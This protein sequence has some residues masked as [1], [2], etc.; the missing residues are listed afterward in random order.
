MRNVTGNVVKGEDFFN[1][2]TEIAQF[3]EALEAHNLLLL[4]PRRVGKT[5]LMY[6]MQEQAAGH[7]YRA[8]FFDTSD[9]ADEAAFV[10]RLFT[11]IQQA[12]VTEESFWRRLKDS[13]VGRCFSRIGSASGFG[14]KLELKEAS[15]DWAEVGEELAR[16]LSQEETRWLIEIDELPVFVLRLLQHGGDGAVERVRLFL[17]WLRRLRLDPACEQVRWLLAG[18]VGL[19]TVTMRH[20]MADT[21]ND[22]ASVKL[23]AFSP[24]VAGRFL[25]TLTATYPRINFPA[26]VQAYAVHKIEWT[27][28]F[29]L[30]LIFHHLR[31]APN[32]HDRPLTE[33][34]VDRAF[35]ELLDSRHR[36]HFDYWRE[37]L[38]L[39]LG[40]P[41]D[42]HATAL[43]DVACHDPNGV[44]QTTLA[45]TLAVL[46]QDAEGRRDKLRYLLDVLEGD[47]YLLQ[48]GG[49]YR[50]RSPLLREYWR[51]RVAP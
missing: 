21:V 42:G 13:P 12:T 14:F 9:V 50:F 19:D 18:S 6:R 32:S 25:A 3:W 49:R 44:T 7:G 37:R 35:E 16:Q 41:E 46:V 10:R 28:P 23:D 39:E 20:R 47:G 29:F 4:S 2:E 8:V 11:T 1:R 45:Q 48:G 40:R 17:Y 38:T 27:I 26:P 15:T 22:L 5:S 43:L 30:Q 33:E 34:D 51:R 31:S 36:T 24:E